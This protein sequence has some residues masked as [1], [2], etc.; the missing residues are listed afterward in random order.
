[1]IILEPLIQITEVVI[2]PFT[3]NAV[4]G[5]ED[6]A[7]GAGT[8]NEDVFV[9]V[10]VV[11]KNDDI[12]AIINSVPNIKKVLHCYSSSSQYATSVLNPNTFFS[13]TAMIT[14]AKK[15]KTIQSI[16]DIPLEHIMIET[17]C[18]YLKPM[19]VD[20][21]E[22]EPAYV[23]HVLEKI[24]KVKGAALDVCKKKIACNSR[25]FFGI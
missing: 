10:E 2:N 7:E 6:V 16:R 9:V 25:A 18:P 13:F 14:H 5:T 19:G 11:G 17:D 3:V 8:T 22:N 1:M 21:A 24:A 12:K 4:E 15:G 20:A 23:W